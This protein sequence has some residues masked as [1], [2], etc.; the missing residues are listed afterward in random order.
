MSHYARIVGDEVKQVIVADFDFIMYYKQ[1]TE[2]KWIQTS[3]NTYGGKHRLGGIPL[4][5]NFASIGFKYDKEKDAFI[6]PKPYE[7]WT[8]D[9]NTC[10]WVAPV[11]MPDDGKIYKW[12]EP[13][14]N[15]VEVTPEPAE[16]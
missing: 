3:Y 4:R 2:G 8:L 14:L 5:K 15:W 7:S 9:E 6:P 16:E 10:L 1:Q 11:A 13:A 12:D